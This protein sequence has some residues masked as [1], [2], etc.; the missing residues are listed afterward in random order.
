MPT[1]TITASPFDTAFWLT[2]GAI[3]VLLML[4]AFFSG[5]E[6]A[7]TAASRGKLRAQGDKGNAGALRALRVMEDSEKLIGAILSGQQRGQHP[8]GRPC[9]RPAVAA[10]RR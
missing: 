1:E 2:T 6:T 4:S 7:L 10:V 9:H 3:I 8:V 5:S